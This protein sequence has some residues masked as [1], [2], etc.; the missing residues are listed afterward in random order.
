MKQMQFRKYAALSVM[1][2]LAS[3]T[4]FTSFAQDDKPNEVTARAERANGLESVEFDTLTGTVE[5]DLPDDMSETDT[6]TGSVI[7]E[8]KGE[9]K[10]EIAQ[11]EDTLTGYVVEIQKTQEVQEPEDSKPEECKP[12]EPE[13]HK[14]KPISKAP[15][16]KSAPPA[17]CPPP[18]IVDEPPHVYA[19][20]HRR[21]S[22][23]FKVP[24]KCGSVKV[25]IKDHYGSLICSKD[26]RCNP[27]PPLS[28]A[29]CSIPPSGTCGKSLS[30]PGPYD[31]RTATCKVAVNGKTCPPVAISPRKYI[32]SMPTNTPGKCNI[33]VNNRGL[34]TRGIIALAPPKYVAPKP[35]AA[36][37][38]PPQAKPVAPKGY[39]FRCTGP[40]ITH[41]PGHQANQT[42]QITQDE[43][44]KVITLTWIGESVHDR[45]GQ[46]SKCT[47]SYTPPPETLRVGEQVNFSCQVT[48]ARDYCPLVSIT[49]GSP[50][51]KTLDPTLTFSNLPPFVMSGTKTF[52]LIDAKKMTDDYYKQHPEMIG[53][54]PPLDNNVEI[55]MLAT[56]PRGYK[57]VDIRYRYVITNE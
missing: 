6:I 32:A 28:P 50:W 9:T 37:V 25:V 46:T 2:L 51:L 20:P 45:G 15:E 13:P 40:F 47:F 8:P 1:V 38:P 10:E 49:C 39:Y 56:G 7:A 53:K 30:I 5:V 44:S 33:T 24:P 52:E 42:V 12:K 14:S 31:G 57:P 34:V 23:T 11:N 16:A 41:A 35:V 17:K 3:S 19:V 27:K 36:S 54:Y 18:K 55:W 22:C 26:V 4:T 21:N 48:Q 43:R 29:K